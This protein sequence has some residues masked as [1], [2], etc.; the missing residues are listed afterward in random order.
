MASSKQS[1]S[2][3]L[4]A[5]IDP[6]IVLAFSDAFS[7][8]DGGGF[9]SPEGTVIGNLLDCRDEGT[10]TSAG[11]SSNDSD[12]GSFV[13]RR[14]TWLR[15]PISWGVSHPVDFAQ[16]PFAILACPTQMVL[17]LLYLLFSRDPDRQHLCC[18]TELVAACVAQARLCTA[19][20]L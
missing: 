12:D 13:F 5:V 2:R 19:R 15:R 4:V 1:H 10:D 7:W 8:P 6:Q 9:T 17:F 16:F 18:N 11:P 14:W 3:A 20:H